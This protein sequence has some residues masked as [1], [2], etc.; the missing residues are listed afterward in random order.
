MKQTSKVL[1]IFI[2]FSIL[3]LFIPFRGLSQAD[4]FYP[5]APESAADEDTVTANPDSVKQ[6]PQHLIQ[7][8]IY[9]IA[10][11]YGD[12]V[13]LRWGAEDY[14]TQRTLDEDGLMI[15]RYDYTPVGND[16][17]CD[18]LVADLR[19]WTLEQ[20]EA[21]YPQ[22]DSIAR[23]AMGVMYSKSGLRPDQTKSAP[24]TFGSFYEIYQDQQTKQAFRMLLA[25]WRKDI[26]DRMA[27]R[28]VDRNVR[29]GHEYEYIVRPIE[30][31]STLQLIIAPAV[32]S[33]K[34]D[35]F[36]KPPYD[37]KIGDTIVSHC[38]LRLWWENRGISSFE[39]DRRRVGEEGWTRINKLPYWNM[40]PEVDGQEIESDSLDCFY[41]DVLPEPGDYEYRIW[42][43]DPFGDL[44]NPSPIY[45]TH[46]PDMQA[47]RAPELVLVEID[48]QDSTDLS[49][50][51][52]ATFH[53][54]KDTLED[55]FIGFMPM[56]YNEHITGQEWRKLAPEM[57][58]PGDSLFTCD[59]TGY[60][61]GM[62][63]V[64]AY[65]TAQN[66]SYSLPR[67]VQI[68]DVK[69]PS[70]MRNFKAEASIEDGT[71]TLTWEPDTLDF[72][73]EYYEVLFANDTTHSFILLNQGKLTEPHYV[74]TVAM[75]VNQKYIYYKVRAIDYSS[76][77]SE[78]T[79]PLQVLRPTRLI[80]D[81]PHL[82]SSSSDSLGIHMEWACSNE[83]IVDHHILLRRLDGQERWDT[84][85]VFPADSVIAWGNSVSYTDTPSYNRQLDY[86]YCMETF[87]CFDISS[88]HSL[89]LSMRY[90]GP[91]IQQI[92]IR[93]EG[94]FL[95]SSDETELS[96]EINGGKPVEGDW[97]I[98]IY[99][100][101]PRDENYSFWI[102]VPAGTTGRRSSLLMPGET[103][104]FYVILRFSDGRESL[105]SNEVTVMCPPDADK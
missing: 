34:N 96:W 68:K 41:G 98:C 3:L 82:L 103:E 55:D 45:R 67:M 21:A 1:S 89:V 64:A 32:L 59:M 62:V 30:Y 31:D 46:V 11:A 51:V 61:T 44:T 40:Q 86:Q 6:P 22:E 85:A 37:I 58:P 81:A 95:T 8:G 33:V 93:L 49:K 60:S 35:R 17:L 63:I 42:G 18:T 4:Y 25:E 10:R 74:D 14:V 36:I 92:P 94:G 26:A 76:N 27:M 54:E 66:I 80:P 84:L 105:M 87:S 78:D 72:D 13:V 53:F 99:R 104:Q 19:P 91:I 56:Y 2:T 79:P 12:S 70:P 7:A 47:P 73:I 48:R 71:I 97:Y 24:G 20:F 9:L 5:Q 90:A 88:G 39:I 43:H 29:P 102:S 52:M 50:K 15:V 83:Q 23:M 77:Q 75:D 38:H 69:A 100:K 16:P 57:L 65:D 101:G 28:W